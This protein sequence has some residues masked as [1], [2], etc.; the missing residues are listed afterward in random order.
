MT[1]EELRTILRQSRTFKQGL[2]EIGADWTK[3]HERDIYRLVAQVLTNSGRDAVPDF[4]VYD[5]V[6]DRK[7][8]HIRTNLEFKLFLECDMNILEAEWQMYGNRPL[9][10]MR[11]AYNTSGKKWRAMYIYVHH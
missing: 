3:R 8:S 11:K 9:E 7:Q 1:G 2:R 6:V 10:D 5:L 4:E